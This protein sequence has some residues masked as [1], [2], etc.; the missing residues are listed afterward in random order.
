MLINFSLSAKV[1]TSLMCAE[2]ERRED[3]ESED[4]YGGF[5]ASSMYQ[6][7]KSDSAADE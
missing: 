6:G 7:S 1:Q 2:E 5:L 4:N 3:A